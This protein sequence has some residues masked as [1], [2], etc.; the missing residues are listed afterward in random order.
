MKLVVLFVL[1]TCGSAFAEPPPV[2]SPIVRAKAEA[3]RVEQADGGMCLPKEVW[4]TPPTLLGVLINK[5]ASA[6]ESGLVTAMI[7]GCKRTTKDVADPFMLLALL[8]LER[9]YGLPAKYQGIFAATWCVEA[10]MRLKKHDGSPVMGDWDPVAKVWRAYGP[11]Q[12]HEWMW[13]W[14]GGSARMAQD[15]VLWS[16]RCWAEH[17]NRVWKYAE[18]CSDKFV[19]AEALVSN[20]KR[21][22]HMKCDARSKHVQELESWELFRVT[23][24]VGLLKWL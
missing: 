9:M 3:P 24:K 13:S 11:L 14:C 20:F 4:H 6:R 18:G 21:Y 17:Y 19:V 7:D 10:A 8:R 23:G 12:M 16:A 1:L 5:P 22:S 15:D 2:I